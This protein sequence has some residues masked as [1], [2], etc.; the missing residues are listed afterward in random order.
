M[1]AD[2]YSL[3]IVF[4]QLSCNFAGV[5]TEKT[6]AMKKERMFKEYI[7]TCL[8]KNQIC[9]LGNPDADILIIG[10]EHFA[11]Q[12]VSDEKWKELLLD[13]Y[14]FCNQYDSNTN[15]IKP[16][17]DIDDNGKL[18]RNNTWCN[19]QD[20]LDGV[21]CRQS[22]QPNMLDFEY[23][24]F[25]TELNSKPKPTSN[26]NKMTNTKEEKEREKQE[27]SDRVFKRLMLLR[28]SEFIKT[29]PVIILACGP[30]VVNQKEK[31]LL[32]INDTFNVV[33]DEELGSN[34]IPEGWHQ[35]EKGKMWFT[36]HHN[37][38]DKTKLVIHTWQLS[39]KDKALLNEMADVIRD[40][41]HKLG[42]L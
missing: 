15:Y 7:N 29:F 40:H 26:T 32:Q 20:L 27:V 8:Q 41:L 35:K 42:L 31:G 17:G 11:P 13:N 28:E 12:E 16:K 25:T 1:E 33:Y 10:Q 4:A 5:F 9:G 2:F 34:G 14:N 23:Y 3:C 37:P 36:T 39:R 24:A 6:T 22:R 18:R 30:Y 19:Y 21:Y 38:N